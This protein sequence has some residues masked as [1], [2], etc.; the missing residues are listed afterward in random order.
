VVSGSVRARLNP[1]LPGS[2]RSA[3]RQGVGGVASG[4]GRHARSGE[5]RDRRVH[6]CAGTLVLLSAVWVARSRRGGIATA[7]CRVGPRGRH[8]VELVV[9]R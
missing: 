9:D 4:A 3:R 2:I 8:L 6:G 1:G 5:A 7:R